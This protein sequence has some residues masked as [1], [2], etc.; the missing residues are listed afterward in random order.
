MDFKLFF[1][2]SIRIIILFS[3]AMAGT[4]IPDHLRVFFGDT[5]SNSI[6]GDPEW[7][8]GVRH[9]WYFWMM[10]L[11]FILSAI[12]VGLSIYKLIKKNHPE[13]PF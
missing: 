2:I 1:G 5:L 9:Y 6:F 10:C 4:F 3:L 11:L 7:K 8:W 13:F 12:N